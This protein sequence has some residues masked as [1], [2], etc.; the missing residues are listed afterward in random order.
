MLAPKFA[1]DAMQAYRMWNEGLT[2]RR[3]DVILERDRISAWDRIARLMGFTSARVAE[4]HERNRRLREAEGTVLEER[5]ALVDRWATARMAGDDEG[6]REALE[7]IRAWNAR[8]YARGVRITQETLQ[9]SAQTRR[10][11]ARLRED[12][13]QIQNR[14][15]GRYLRG[16]QPA[17]G[18]R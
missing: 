1:R 8:P 3:G 6:R 5:R 13:V 14:P 9:R 2:T 10:R 11:N 7:R 4:T 15:L 17:P 16:L 12:G 18:Y